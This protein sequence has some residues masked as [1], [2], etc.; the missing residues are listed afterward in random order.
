MALAAFRAIAHEPGPGASATGLFGL[1]AEY[2]H[3]LLNPL[4]VCGLAIGLAILALGFIRHSR[5]L[6]TT[7]LA[8]SALCAASAWPVLYYGQHAYNSLAP[9]LDSESEQWLDT[10]M[11]RAERFVY[12]FYATAALCLVESSLR[13][14][15]GV[16][17]TP[18]DPLR[19]VRRGRLCAVRRRNVSGTNLLNELC[20]ND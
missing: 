3:V 4:P 1:E 10:H 20:L 19:E 12:F 7:G 5:P 16:I 15:E 2:V 17:Q 13:S 8:L 14:R 11:E 6:R 18:L 9:M